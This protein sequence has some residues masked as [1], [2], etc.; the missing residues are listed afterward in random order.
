VNNISQCIEKYYSPYCNF[1]PRCLM[2]ASCSG[3]TPMLK[4]PPVQLT[5]VNY[6]GTINMELIY[7]IGQN[8]SFYTRFLYFICPEE[9]I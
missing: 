2:L 8:S 1:Q 3:L 5:E 9:H 7:G 4:V 6:I